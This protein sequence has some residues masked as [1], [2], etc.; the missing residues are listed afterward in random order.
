MGYGYSGG[1]VDVVEEKLLK[2][3]V[4]T[5]FK[6]LTDALEKAYNEADDDDKY[7]YTLDSDLDYNVDYEMDT[8]H[9]VAIAYKALT[10][11]F[12]KETGLSLWHGYHNQEDEGSRYDEV[13]G[14]YWAVGNVHT[15][16]PEALA[17]LDKYGKTAITNA[18]YVVG[19]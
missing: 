4:P 13:D 11:A 3:I 8:D 19:G 5:E 9:P 1:N 6:A 17:F 7:L 18:S 15:F 2:R 10:M 16:T 12:Q 14:S